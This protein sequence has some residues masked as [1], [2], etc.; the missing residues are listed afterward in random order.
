MK[1][2][3]LNIWQGRFT[4]QTKAFIEHEQPDIICMQEVYSSKLDT[5][6]MPFF[7]ALERIAAVLPDY[8]VY[9]SP[10]HKLVI[11]GEDVFYGNAILSRHELKDTET[12]FIHGQ[13]AEIDTVEQMDSNIRNMQRAG[14]ELPDGKQ[15]TI[16]NHHGY[17]EPNEVGSEITVDRMQKVADVIK[18]SPRPLVFAGDL[19]IIS[20]SPA[21]K[22]IHEQLRDLTD[23]YNLPTTLSSFGKVKN[24]ACD[25]I[26]VSEEI[27]VRS[28]SASD[29]LV[30][31][32]LALILEFDVV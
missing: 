15:M 19:Q 32:H 21:M 16:I 5:P 26:C 4:E 23:E 14:I 17:W 31:D 25:H 24:V 20:R 18:D 13:Y 3:Q 7:N 1:I 27:K 30:S 28:F 9:F 8:D 22:P 10:V 2:I 12:F 11:L 6:L 29:I